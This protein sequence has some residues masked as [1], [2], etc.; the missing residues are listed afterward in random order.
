MIYIF[1]GWNFICLGIPTIVDSLK[2]TLPL[3]CFF[4]KITFTVLTLSFGFQ[5]GEVT[6]LFFIGS[7]LGNA[8]GHI[9]GISPIFL[10]TLGF[11]AVFSGDTDTPLACFIMCIELFNG[12]GIEYL[13]IAALVSYLFSKHNGIYSSQSI[14]KPKYPWIDIDEKITLGNYKKIHYLKL[15]LLR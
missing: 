7:T 9:L 14:L 13:F 6:R 11:I 8:L 12:Q 10:A 5:V 3:C 4:P 2:A 1:N 15:Y